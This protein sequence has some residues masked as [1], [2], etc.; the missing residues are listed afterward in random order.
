MKLKKERWH[1]WS[2]VKTFFILFPLEGFW[3]NLYLISSTSYCHFP[4][5]VFRAPRPSV[6]PPPLPNTQTL[7]HPCHDR[8]SLELRLLNKKRPP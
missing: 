1:L 7:K 5:S 6:N 8:N 4:S 2:N 3:S